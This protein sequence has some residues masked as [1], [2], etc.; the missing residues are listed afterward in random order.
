MPTTK[1]RITVTLEPRQY[2]LLK[3]IS[4]AGGDSMSKLVSELLGTVEPTLERMALMLQ[5]L[6]KVKRD[7]QEEVRRVLGDVHN[8]LES[9]MEATISQVDMFV[10]RAGEA[11]ATRAA[12]EAGRGRVYERRAASG[13]GRKK[14]VSTPLCNTGVR[15]AKGRR[16]K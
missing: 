9:L 16:K 10:D 13:K 4:S 7:E 8:G 6:R 2:E 3:Q 11:T 12:S 14:A 15:S 1:P 5:R